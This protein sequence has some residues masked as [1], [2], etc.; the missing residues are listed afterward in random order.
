VAALKDATKQYNSDFHSTVR[1]APEEVGENDVL[2]FMTMKDNADKF[3]HNAKS[4]ESRKNAFE[5][6]GSFRVPKPDSTMAFKRGFKATYGDKEDVARIEGSKVIGSR[7]TEMDQKLLLPTSRDATTERAA[8]EYTDIQKQRKRE[9]LIEE[10][11][12][13]AVDRLINRGGQTSLSVVGRSIR[14]S[15]SFDYV[16][17]MKKLRLVRPGMLADAIRLFG[18]HYDVE[19][20]RDQFVRR[21]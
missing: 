13:E 19:G 3:K 20:L 16:A 2:T 8:F 1:D 4:L 12:L 18:D 14:A 7:G 21:V 9:Q 5:T 17:T 10:G 11:F 15:A 6:L